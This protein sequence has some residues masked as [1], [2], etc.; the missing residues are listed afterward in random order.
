MSKRKVTRREFL[1][2]A[3][4]T[5]AGVALPNSVVGAAQTGAATAKPAQAG[6]KLGQR[7]IGKLEGPEI[8]RDVTKFPKTFKEA[9]MLAELVKAGKLPPVDKR[10]PDPSDV[11]VIK[12]LKEV[13]KYG[14][15]WRR[16]FT[17]PADNENGNRIVSTDKILM[18][19]YTGNKVA[20]SLAK[21]WRLS[22]DGRIATIFLRK[23]IKWSDGQPFTADDFIFWYND[24][25]QNK[26]LVPTQIPELTINGKPGRMVKRDDYTVVFEFP[27]PYFLFVDILAGDTLIGG[28]QA[29][30][31]ARAAFMGA[32]APAHYLKQFLPKYSSLDEAQRKAKAAGFDSW[33]SYFRNRTNWALNTELPVMGPW[34]TVSPI[35]TP[36]WGMERNPYYWAVD[37]AGNQLP[38]IDRLVM[39]LAE[40]LEVLNLRAVAGE[41][42]LQERHISLN[43]LPV[44]IENQKKGNYS[45]HLDTSQSGCDAGM[46]INTAY[47]ADPEIAKWLNN[48]DFRHAL[49]LGIDRDQLNE[50]FWLGIGTPGSTAPAEEVAISPGKEYRKKWAVL[51]VKQANGLLDKVGLTKKDGQGYRLRTDGKGR[52]RI[53][54]MTVGGQF[55]P[56]TQVAE[57]IKQHWQ[58]IGID[59]DVKETERS[60]A[61]TKTA[62]AE[63]HI[64][65]WTVGGSENL[66]LFPR[67]V[68]PVDPA[69]CHLGMPFARWYASNGAQGKKPTNPE[70]LRA[71]DLYRSAAGKK[72]PE[73]IK[74]AQEIWKILVEECWVIGTVG[75]SPA[76]MG[77]R[78]VKNNMGN[79]PMRQT[80]AQHARTPNTSH[81]AT[82]YFKS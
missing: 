29:T 2:L 11:L 33:V 16:G 45:I 35:N 25:Y 1:E 30:G 81:P 71:F 66:Y 69:E 60:L 31:A 72:E 80:N 46:L 51:D 63:H 39:N 82:F 68:L 22:D 44:F 42:D 57:M 65:F 5:A 8:I 15:R 26:D 77:V 70:M 37:T 67:H 75:L 10:L 36:T 61:F 43:K 40:N 50:A 28:G 58:K 73:R 52:V 56:Y 79:I 59:A 18:W 48:R 21:D 74:I 9:P 19:D 78:I 49:A 13:G 23:G 76:F 62:N 54:L 4:L 53:E 41:Y 7:L 6:E 14:G 3:T 32:Y 27:E 34:K 24:I 64:M 55:I 12:P 20:P 17:G 47:E 38:Y